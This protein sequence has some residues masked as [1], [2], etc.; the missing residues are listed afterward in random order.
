MAEFAAPQAD[1]GQRKRRVLRARLSP[2]ALLVA[3]SAGILLAAVGVLAIW[4]AAT[5]DRDTSSVTATIPST[6]LG[7]E[8]KVAR[9]DVEIVAGNPNEVL[10]SRTEWSAFGRR[11]EERRSILEG[12]L[13]IESQC[14]SL[15]LGKCAAD[16]RL[17]V[18]ENVPVTVTAERGDIRLDAY[19]GSARVSTQGGSIEAG[20][21]CGPLLHATAKG[22]DIDVT[23]A[24]SSERIV[25]RTD[26]GDVRVAVPQATYSIDADTNAGRLEVRG[27]AL[28]DR[29]RFAI[30][31]LSNTGDVT[32]EARS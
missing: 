25:V 2:W 19:R 10:V 27:L 13:T 18:P 20:A 9:G 12:V 28:A 6:L 17:T 21:F 1:V 22:G 30:Q 3:V 8:L 29:A 11:P 5:Y 4:W 14:A 7:V 16:Y 15:V 32:V 26:S 31:A 24:C 23:T